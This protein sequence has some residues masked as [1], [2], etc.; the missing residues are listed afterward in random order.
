MIDALSHFID[1]A[2]F[3]APLYYILGFV[4]AALIPVIPTPL[5]AALGGTTLGYGAAAIY[6]IIG[7]GVGA[8][9]SLSLARLVGRPL[10]RRLVKREAWENWEKFLSIESVLT[11]G[12]IFLVTN[13]D[14]VVM[15]SGLTSIRLTSLW[16]TAVL[17]RTPWLLASVWLGDVILV[18]DAVAVI[19][20]LLL[21][22]GV[23]LFGKVRPVLERQLLRLVPRDARKAKDEAASPGPARQVAA[24]PATGTRAGP[25]GSEVAQPGIEDVADGIP[26]QVEA[27]D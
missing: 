24:A 6:G 21:I 27:N 22:P 11:W 15:L 13:I 16:L 10:L 8:F 9:I 17:V 20:L 5:I 12:L 19:L 3:F 2:G 7:L 4:I 1:N 14:F 25:N 23:Y 26:K 18:N